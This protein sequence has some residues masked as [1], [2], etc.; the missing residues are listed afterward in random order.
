MYIFVAVEVL[1]VSR[2]SQ[3][4]AARVQK[5]TDA[6]L[7]MEEEEEIVFKRS[8]TVPNTPRAS[9][10]NTP[11]PDVAQREWYRHRS[12][13]VFALLGVVFG[14]ANGVPHYHLQPGSRNG[15]DHW[16]RCF[17]ISVAAYTGH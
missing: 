1:G 5:Q 17:G 2:K 15:R 14:V 12:I 7:A 4:E 9:R 13:G 3:R 11:D 8:R 10:A 6:A 16:D